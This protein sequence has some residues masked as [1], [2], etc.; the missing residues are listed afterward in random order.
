M[1]PHVRDTADVPRTDIL[2]ERVGELEH[3]I[4]VRDTADVPRTDISEPR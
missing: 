1:S 2:V 4:H 3:V